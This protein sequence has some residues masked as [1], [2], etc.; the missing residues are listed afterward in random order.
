MDPE[1]AFFFYLAAVVCLVVAAAG[2]SWRLG[3]RTRRGQ[4]P[5]LLLMPLGIALAIVPTLWTVGQTAF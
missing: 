1:V 4:A 3:A 2:E 5:L